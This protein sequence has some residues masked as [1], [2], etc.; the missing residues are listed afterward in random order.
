[1]KCTVA[2]VRCVVTEAGVI[3][4]DPCERGVPA[5]EKQSRRADLTFVFDSVEKRSV[6]CVATG[7]YSP[8]EF[9]EAMSVAQ[10]ASEEVFLF[11]KTSLRKFTKIL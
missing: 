9:Q 4:L 5:D 1:M 11:Y 3:E 10:S 7:Q 6:S 2:A 8:E